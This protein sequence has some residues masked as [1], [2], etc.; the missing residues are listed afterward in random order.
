MFD[1]LFNLLLSITKLKVRRFLSL[2]NYIW[3]HLEK[4]ILSELVWN[5]SSN[6]IKWF[7]NL[8]QS[9]MEFTV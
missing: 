2:V 9:T 8:M 4:L 6:L 7:Y 3:E 5:H 1:L